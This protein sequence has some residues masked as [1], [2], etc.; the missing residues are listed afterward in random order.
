MNTNHNQLMRHYID[1]VENVSKNI[2]ERM[3]Q[4]FGQ[5]EGAEKGQLASRVFDFFRRR[6][7]T[8]TSLPQLHKI[9]DNNG[10]RTELRFEG[11]PRD[12]NNIIDVFVHGVSDSQKQTPLKYAVLS[13]NKN[14]NQIQMLITYI[15]ENKPEVSV[16]IK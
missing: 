4:A 2:I 6:D 9:L 11:F 3:W 5:H 16:D 10:K 14:Q 15:D 8:A 13:S 7:F 12:G 1:I